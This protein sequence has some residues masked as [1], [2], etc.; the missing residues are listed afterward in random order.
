MPKSADMQ[1]YA[2]RSGDSGVVAYLLGTGS[3][4]VEFHGGARYLYD[5]VR[6]GREHVARMTV[7]AREGR[8]LS[9]YIS[10]NVREN[11]RAPLE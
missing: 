10:R 8:G 9:S 1:P 6:P 5:R 3:I 2:N 7:L 4:I 11:Y